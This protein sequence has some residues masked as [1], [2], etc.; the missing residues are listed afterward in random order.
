M[1]N[2]APGSGAPYVWFVVPVMP[3]LWSQVWSYFAGGHGTY[4]IVKTVQG[5]PLYNQYLASGFPQYPSYA[6]AVAGGKAVTAQAKANTTQ[7]YVPGGLTP[8]DQAAA[9]TNISLSGLLPSLSN[10][11]DFVARAVKV[12]IGAALIIAGVSSLMKSQGI[13]VPKVVPVPV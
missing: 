6:A 7:P 5:N 11:R 1:T 13:D 2:V 9:A 10:T 4:T 8:G 3:G 12:I